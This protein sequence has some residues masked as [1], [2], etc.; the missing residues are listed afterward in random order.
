MTLRLKTVLLLLLLWTITFGLLYGVAWHP[1]GQ[2]LRHLELAENNQEMQRVIHLIRIE[3]RN[4]ARDVN[5]YATWDDMY[6][7]VKT[8]NPRFA[9]SNFVPN[10]FADFRMNLLLVLSPEGDV[11]YRAC[12]D[13]RADKE[14]ELAEF[15]GPRIPRS[16]PVFLD[17]ARQQELSG[18][19]WTAQGLLLVAVR[20]ILKSDA[21]GEP[22]GLVVMGR[23]WDENEL[24]DFGDTVQF[25]IAL[26]RAPPAAPA[27]P[28]NPREF[29]FTSSSRAVDGTCLLT[30]VSGAPSI[31]LHVR[32]PRDV[33]RLALAGWSWTA[34]CIACVAL[35]SGLGLYLIVQQTVLRRLELLDRVVA[36]VSRQQ[37]PGLPI[38]DLGRDEVGRLAQQIQRMLTSLQVSQQTLAENEKQLRQSQT[39]EA[40][41]LLSSGIAHDFNN[42]L[43]GILGHTSLAAKACVRNQ[44]AKTAEHL[45]VVRQAATRG[46]ALVQNL[47]TFCR[48]R[49]AEMELVPLNELMSEV[50]DFLT[51]T[52]PRNI[53]L[54]IAP[55]PQ[56]PCIQANRSQMQQ[57]MLNLCLN[58]RDA[59]P[60]G[61]KLT[62][63]SASAT[64]D[65]RAPLAILQ[66]QDTG[67][68]MTEE[69]QKRMFEPF[70]TTK[71]PGSGTGLGL[72]MVYGTVQSAGGTIACESAPGK[73]TVFTLQFPGVAAG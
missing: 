8:R 45:D 71:T 63:R 6:D 25:P 16:S 27:F 42:V 3:Q 22:R 21:S 30:D 61:G 24:A 18:L 68:G 58:A 32:L 5:D 47:L 10:L 7:Y 41:G 73:G 44:P 12:R 65:D 34:V 64:A 50:A 23:L 9:A 52:L 31:R 37:D 62:L 51:R 60:E 4:L 53:A 1:F 40:I 46:A 56:N 48:H 26:Q 15:N 54:D 38:P 70:F 39:L 59:M 2:Q 49:K 19:M 20:P 72:P 28:P 33:F 11:V 17:P 66:V 57:A 43:Q 14:L 67:Q 55:A 69:V 13:Y 29:R 36:D 35:A